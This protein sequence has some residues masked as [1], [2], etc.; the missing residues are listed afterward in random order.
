MNDLLE[1]FVSRLNQTGLRYMVTGSVATIYYGESR[2]TLD[3]DIILAL[4]APSARILAKV[5]P[6][7]EFYLPPVEVMEVEARR[8]ERGHFNILHHETGGRA[9]IYLHAGDPFQAW[10]FDHSVVADVDGLPVRFAPVEYTMLMKLEFYR[11]GG[12]EKH[13]RDIHGILAAGEPIRTAEV[14][15]F[16]S[17]RGLDPLW[18]KHVLALLPG[19]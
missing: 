12:S 6:E 8:R 7:E 1:T 13:L 10:A 15:R 4:P 18:E 9:D 19:D 11:E 16:V 5:F 3:V 2:H 14:A 17:A